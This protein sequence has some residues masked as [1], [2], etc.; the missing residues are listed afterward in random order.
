[1][2]PFEAALNEGYT[3]DEINTHLA[4]RADAARAEGYSDGEIQSYIDEQIK[5]KNPFNAAAV[6]APAQQALAAR[7][8]PKTLTEAISTGWGWSTLGLM[9]EMTR[10][11]HQGRLPAT[12]I[13][14]ET[15]FPL[16][17]AGTVAGMLGDI[18]AFGTGMAAGGG[19]ASPITAVAGGM[20]LTSGL[21]KVFIDAL[22]NNE[23]ETKQEFAQRTAATM[24]ETAK[25]WITGAATGGA[26]SLASKALATS[27]LPAAV[28]SGLTTAAELTAMTEVSA[29]LEGHA[30]EPRDFALAAVT[31]GVIKA[32]APAWTA[33]KPITGVYEKT[34]VMPEQLLKDALAGDKGV[35]QDTLDGR[36]PDAYKDRV[37]QPASAPT[38]AQKIDPIVKAAAPP[39][40]TPAPEPVKTP[41]AKPIYEMSPEELDAAATAAKLREDAL[42]TSAF[43]TD[44]P[45]VQRALRTLETSS[46]DAR[47]KAAE[48]QL[49]VLTAKH[50]VTREDAERIFYG[51]GETE[52]SAEQY[53]HFSREVN[54]LDI[55]S[56][57]ALGASLRTAIT[58]VGEQSDPARMSPSE[59]VAY[60]KIRTAF[61][62]AKEQGW[63][64]QAVSKAAIEG[65]ASRF[66]DPAD[67][68][69]MLQR[70]LKPSKSAPSAAQPPSPKQLTGTSEVPPSKPA[71]EPKTKTVPTL[72]PEQQAQAR[73]FMEHPFAEVPQAPNEPSRPTHLNYNYAQT[74]TE[75][76][77]S[78]AQLSTIYEE[79][80]KTRQQSPRGWAKSQEDAG[81]VLSDLLQT[82]PET[83]TKFLKGETPG[84][85]TTAQIL[86]RKE[87][88]LTATEDLMRARAG[89]LAKGEAATPEDLAGFMARVEQVAAIQA[90]FLGQ[91]ADVGRALNALKSTQRQA[92]RAQALLDTINSYGGEAGVKDLVKHLG[93]FDNPAQVVGFAKAATKATTREMLVEAWKA[94][95]V[96]GLRTN[97]V[98]FLSTA[99]FTAL[100][101]PTEAIA[102]ARGLA[103]TSGERVELAEIPARAVG[104]LAGIRDGFKLAGAVL[105]TGEQT[106]G[107]K[108]DTF[109]KK[110]PGT[111]GEVVRSTFRP[112][113]ASDAL[114]RTINERGEL[115]ALA[116][117]KALEERN[118][119]GAEERA[120]RSNVWTEDNKWDFFAQYQKDRGWDT[121]AS[122]RNAAETER[123]WQAAKGTARTHEPRAQQPDTGFFSRVDDLVKNPT[124][125]ML[126]QA[127]TEGARRTLTT[128]LGPGGQAFQRMVK[129]WGLEWVFP[130]TTTPGN[131]FKETARMTPGVSFLVREWRADYEAG[132]IRRDRALAEV[133]VGSAIMMAVY[134]VAQEGG[135]TGGGQPDPRRRA[136][137]RAAGWKPY[138]V[139]INGQYYDGYLRMAPIGPLIGLTVDMQEF[140]GYMT[141][142]E[143]DQWARM[144]AFAF[145]NNATNQSFFT[146]ATNMV[147]VLQD[148]SRYGQNYFESLAGS[149]VPSLIGQTAADMDPY[150]RQI[151]G[152]R[153][154]IQARIPGWREG[155]MPQRDLF[156]QPIPSPERLWTGSPFTV[157]AASTDKVRTE[158]SRVGF[159][160]PVI[161]K[162]VDVVPGM[163]LGATD[164]VQLTPEQRDIFNSQS[165]QLAH[166]VLEKEVTSQG[167]DGMP[168]IIKRQLFEKA[169]KL[170][171][172]YAQTQL[173]LHQD[174][175][176]TQT[177]VQELQRRLKEEK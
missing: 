40:P 132:G 101:L 154:A 52:L 119:F 147:N 115:Y 109:Q 91:R 67:A 135:I 84:P 134:G 12:A 59:Q 130:F 77:Q 92:E 79:Q 131:I 83:A 38:Q 159:A 87:L 125:D 78:L 120:P 26:G 140:W 13:T 150:V 9:N 110:I 174:P 49:E 17:A 114:L 53:R 10:P 24:W 163:K 146:G 50:G 144:L 171:R 157:S 80:I 100:K 142:G 74:T 54:Q 116:T 138:A 3:P 103:R 89:L 41:S 127:Q 71:P 48:D 34:G 37:E 73:A 98:N 173:L 158:A 8:S 64:L 1:M 45:L 56:P 117:R 47:L 161:P 65:A 61:A 25:G 46:N 153:D 30:P 75:V 121:A 104:M 5:Q 99:M 162:S 42:V 29:R 63:D 123:A 106:T 166:A 6:A 149:V 167:W 31:L 57:Q 151:Q 23:I 60:A 19:P 58:D 94:G 118:G 177:A 152:M 124:K 86:A 88:V 112:L 95:L 66:S 72:T 18:P 35:W 81:K 136:T 36:V 113:A 62:Y 137:D 76:K 129:E 51:I 16:A 164:T 141:H 14:S 102:A 97:E 44:A 55:E 122:F 148:P 69:F 93:E 111:L 128:P 165:G 22:T 156:G 32:V 176:V 11:D 169:F 21:R 108:T 90:G 4:Q 155:L 96:S 168:L 20:G 85:S 27:P 70:F 15:P 68:L 28:N 133:A 2:T 145:A 43:G 39:A 170:S 7:P 105:R 139:K 172:D 107:A 33:M 175:A 126:E 82:D 143:R 160:S